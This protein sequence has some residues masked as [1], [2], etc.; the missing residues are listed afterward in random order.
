MGNKSVE[1]SMDFHYKMF[2]HYFEGELDVRLGR[3]EDS[4][5][6]SCAR[7]LGHD[8]DSVGITK[9]GYPVFIRL[10]D[11]GRRHPVLAD[12]APKVGE[13][14][15]PNMLEKQLIFEVGFRRMA[16]ILER[17]RKNGVL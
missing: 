17:A 2:L 13:G 12:L 3:H 15:E 10:R 7:T 8:N 11:L 6:G 4:F 14:T 16:E 9:D 1:M 5:H